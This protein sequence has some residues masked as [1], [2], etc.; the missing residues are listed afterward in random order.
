MIRRFRT[1]FL[2]NEA[3][4]QFW[5]NE[6]AEFPEDAPARRHHATRQLKI[7][8]VQLC[9]FEGGSVSLILAVISRLE[10][11]DES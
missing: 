5:L 8:H 10:D 4:L 11:D 6:M 9:L 7:E 2:E 1:A 3:R